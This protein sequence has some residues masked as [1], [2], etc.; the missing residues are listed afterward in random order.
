[1]GNFSQDPNARA[2]DAAGKQYVAVRIQQAVPLVDA[3]WNLLDDIRRTEL[4]TFGRL[5]I[6]SGIPAGSDGFRISAI[7]QANDFAIAPGVALVGGKTVRN[8]GTPPVRYTTQ[9]NFARAGLTAL[10]TPT[11]NKGVFVVLDVSER[12]V[13]H[14]EDPALVD[15]RI[16][17]ETAVRL[18]REWVVRVFRDPEDAPQIDTPPAGHAYLRLARIARLANNANIT[19]A[20]IT[21][22]RDTQLTVLRKIEIRDNT[23]NLL[24]TNDLF[25]Q[26][27][28]NTRN[29]IQA[30]LK[31]ITTQFNSIYVPMSAVEVLGLTSAAHV[32][33]TAEAGLAQVSTQTIANRGALNVLRQLYQAEQVFM[34]VWKDQVLQ[35][36]TTV[37]KYASYLSFVTNLNSRLNDPTVGTL[38]GLDAALD[39]G[40]LGAAVNM[41]NEIARL[42]GAA[43]ATIARGS[44][45]VSYVNAPPGNLTQGQVVRFEFHVKSFTTQAD[46]Y[47]VT[48][49]PPGGWQR[50]VVDGQNNPVPNNKVPIGAAGTETT[51]FVRTTVGAGSSG[52]Q[53]RV[54]SDTNPAEI[55]QTTGLQTLTQGQPA[56]LGED[57]IQLSLEVFTR[58]TLNPATGI[59]SVSLP[60]AQQ[61]GSIGVRIFNNTGQ[62]ATFTLNAEIVPNTPVVGSWPSVVRVG[63]ASIPMNAGDN[64][65]PGGIAITAGADAVSVTVRYTVSATISGSPVTAQ[66]VIPIVAT[67]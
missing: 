15:A 14:L 43:A 3:D 40:D 51:I 46:T 24:V 64:Q 45:Q 65:R 56:P 55:D 18:K 23:G 16:G 7:A 37:K 4:E 36:G 59:V 19:A 26:T 42:I 63:P 54:T 62:A 41:Q 35:L 39:T 1:M 22:L 17:V 49:L 47:T 13:D 12:E 21:D 44:I 67:P 27:L 33:H 29:N 25:Q 8:D 6:G 53:L 28:E 10:T 30:F 50:D 9:P 52:L 20:M 60:P 66:I 58:A 32:A 5:F 31:Y 11:V 57:K 38:T 61:P 2:A 34:Q 48:V